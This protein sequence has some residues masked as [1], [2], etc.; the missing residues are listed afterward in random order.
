MFDIGFSEL[1]LLIVIGLVVVGPD[2]LPGVLRSVGR[3]VGQARRYFTNMQ[4]QIERE[5]RLEELNKKIMETSNEFQE[6]VKELEEKHRIAT[7]ELLPDNPN[8]V[9]HDDDYNPI[10]EVESEKK[11]YDNNSDKNT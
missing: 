4:N 6:T 11:T 2:R 9:D 10:P 1:F 3:T 8:S 7:D 5:I